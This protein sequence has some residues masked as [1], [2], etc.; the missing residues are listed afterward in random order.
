MWPASHH[1]FHYANSCAAQTPEAI[2]TSLGHISHI[3]ML[4]AHYLAVRL[5]AEITLPHRDY[6][7]PTIF[8]LAGSYHH[9]RVSFP[10]TPGA[11]TVLHDTQATSSEH[12]PTPR[13]LYIDKPLRQFAK[14]NSAAFS[15]FLEGVTLLAYNIAWLCCSQGVSIGDKSSFDDIC[16]MGK[17]LY[18]LL[19][20]SCLQ[21]PLLT[22]TTNDDSRPATNKDEAAPS[23]IGRYSHGTTFYA[24]GGSDGTELVR[25]FKLPSPMKLADKL[26]KKILGEAP[27]PDWE[28]LD[29]DAW[30]VDDTTEAANGKELPPNKPELPKAES[31]GWMKVKSR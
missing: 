3:L 30:K 24:L 15:F 8:N 2:S 4:I 21:G 6:P 22:S 10:G 1:F 29:D 20:S 13:P 12:S 5:P 14:E 17:N 27:I 23:W 31:K 28:L 16:N 19:V 7:R 11:T 18:S 25:T 26:K 9:E